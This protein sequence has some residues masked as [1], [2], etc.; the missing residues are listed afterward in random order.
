MRRFGLLMVPLCLISTMCLAAPIIYSN[1]PA[2]SLPQTIVQAPATFGAFGGTFFVADPTT[3]GT[4]AD[5]AGN[6]LVVPASAGGSPSTFAATPYSPRS[7][8]FLPS[9]FGG[10]YAG[11]LSV[12]NFA[13]NAVLGVDLAANFGAITVYDPTGAQRTLYSASNFNPVAQAIAPV[14]FGSIGNELIVSYTGTS[15]GI[16]VIDSAGNRGTDL[17]QVNAFAPFGIA[18]APAGFGGLGGRLFFDSDRT[19]QVYS[20]DSN[21]NSAL[22]ATLPL[23]PTKGLRYLGFAPST[24]GAWAGDLIVA[25]PGSSFSSKDGGLFAINSAGVVVASLTGLN[26]RGFTFINGGTQMILNNVD[27]QVFTALPTD[28]TAA[29]PEPASFTLACLALLAG[30]LW[31]RKP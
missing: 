17:F 21:G 11:N 31:R 14:G 1:F 30:G 23:A 19:P 15:A 2:N 18:F 16:A 10:A 13:G 5:V 25:V 9:N 3:S 7:A 28:F 8:I 22:F 12:A 6:I 24:F 27:P 29:V 20:V 4:P 26:P